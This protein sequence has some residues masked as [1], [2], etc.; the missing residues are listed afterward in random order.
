MPGTEV[1]IA[2]NGPAGLGA[3]LGVPALELAQAAV[4]VED[5]DA[6][7]ILLELRGRGRAG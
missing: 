4:H 2:R 3:R 6:L 7:L 5:D 1:S